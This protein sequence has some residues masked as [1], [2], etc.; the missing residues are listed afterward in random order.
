MTMLK[1][2][3]LEPAFVIHTQSF[4]ES[5]VIAVLFTRHFGKISVIA[6]GAQRPKSKFKLIKTPATLFSISS[7]GKTDLQTLI[8]CEITEYFDPSPSSYNFLV[9]LNELLTKMLGRED[10][11]VEVF[12][13]YLSI[14]R[15]LNNSDRKEIEANIRL[16]EVILLR[17]AG[18]GLDFKSEAH[19]EEIIKEDSTYKFDPM[20]GFLPLKD[21][22]E[23]RQD[24]HFKGKDII[25]FSRGDLSS[26]STR[27]AS[28]KIMRQA[29]DFHL[30]AKKIKIRE[31]LSLKEQRR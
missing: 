16:F 17:E 31:Y 7:R 4:S 11:H 19:S 24:D 30:G 6:K 1:T 12:D 26:S 3:T 22:L 13:Q 21:Q 18:Y 2:I 29:L 14:C 5:S 25:N 28:K 15:S 23:N 8:N 9:Y 27:K 20:S 10:A